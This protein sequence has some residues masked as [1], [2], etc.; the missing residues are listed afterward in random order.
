MGIR[1]KFLNLNKL[2]KK[3]IREGNG[4]ILD[5]TVDYLKLHKYEDMYLKN[6]I[7]SRKFG[8]REND[9]EEVIA[10]LYT[11][12]C[13]KLVGQKYE[14]KICGDCETKVIKREFPI[15]IRLWGKIAPYKIM[16]FV[17]LLHL[18]KI[19]SKPNFKKL[20]SDKLK[21]ISILTLYDRFDYLL[22]EYGNS[23]RKNEIA[24][25]K[26]NKDDIFTSYIPVISKKVR[27]VH[28][29]KSI[30]NHYTVHDMNSIYTSISNDI[31]NLKDFCDDSTP[32]MTKKTIRAIQKKYFDLGLLIADIIGKGKNK[33]LRSEIYATR[34][35]FTAMAVIVPYVT[36]KLD[37]ITVPYDLF[38]GLYRR[39]IF[40]ALL[41]SGVKIDKAYKFININIGLTEKNKNT[42]E[43]ILDKNI[44]NPYVLVNRQ[45]TLKFEST[46]SLKIVGL[47]DENVLRVPSYLLEGWNG[48]HDG[49]TLS[50]IHEDLSLYAKINL[51]MQPKV[52]LI[53]Y[54]RDVND[55]LGLIK[56]H[57]LI[58]KKSLEE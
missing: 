35:P 16:T 41:K 13:E 30:V 28:K 29:A 31:Q 55:G 54:K 27:F 49:D 42:L 37:E 46:K 52:H 15:S 53:D 11:C 18:R 23:T 34:L 3:D 48:D 56:D 7:Y 25:L 26:K 20:L 5:T 24:Y 51:H 4:F 8:I 38:R 40:D 33:I 22:E 44:K 6:S 45:P 19:I 21:G 32:K 2:E 9:P 47:E 1:F 17:G 10:Y 50:I 14:G 58:F 43:E 36:K 39:E 57:I 12:D